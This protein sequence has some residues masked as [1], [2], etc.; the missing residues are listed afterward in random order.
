[1]LLSTLSA[2]WFLKKA[3]DFTAS[4][5]NSL[6]PL[7][8]CD[9][10]KLWNTSTKQSF[11]AEWRRFVLIVITSM[12]FLK[13]TV[14]GKKLQIFF[15]SRPF[16]WLKTNDFSYSNFHWLL[17]ALA[18]IANWGIK[19]FERNFYQNP[20]QEQFVRELSEEKFPALI[21]CQ[22]QFL[23]KIYRRLQSTSREWRVS[24][25]FG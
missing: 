18:D 17:L 15:C 9:D 21:S 24:E 5:R 3:K 12:P 11:W 23:L 20:S 10:K 19:L 4:H 22:V 16:E 25:L 1:M 8:D 14:H 7:F 6:P 2:C 13:G